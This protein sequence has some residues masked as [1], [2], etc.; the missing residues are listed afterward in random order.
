MS[1]PRNR[2]FAIRKE[3]EN[4]RLEKMYG[5][6]CLKENAPDISL[7]P[8]RQSCARRSGRIDQDGGVYPDMSCSPCPAPLASSSYARIAGPITW[9]SLLPLRV[10]DPVPDSQLVD[11]RHMRIG[12]R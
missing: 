6:E 3:G 1:A 9:T 5:E 10:D 8:Y 4:G 12:W 7:S 2:I 11:E